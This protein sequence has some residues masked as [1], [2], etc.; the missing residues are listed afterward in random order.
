MSGHA[1]KQY[2]RTGVTSKFFIKTKPPDFARNLAALRNRPAV[3]FDL[4]SFRA[5]ILPA[6]E[7]G[8]GVRSHDNDRRENEPEQD[9]PSARPIPGIEAPVCK[10]PHLLDTESECL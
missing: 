2:R 8:H 1:F 9:T 4:H 10:G 7:T 6:D 3:T 5:F